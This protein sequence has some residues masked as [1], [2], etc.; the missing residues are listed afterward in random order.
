MKPIDGYMS[1]LQMHPAVYH[2]KTPTIGAKFAE[3]KPTQNWVN[4]VILKE[5]GHFVPQVKVKFPKSILHSNNVFTYIP[6]H[7]G[8]RFVWIVGPGV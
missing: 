5:D 8:Y 1:L 4:W 7:R 6:I 2:E 3:V